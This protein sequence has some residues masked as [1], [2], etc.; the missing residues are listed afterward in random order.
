MEALMNSSKSIALLRAKW[1]KWKDRKYV[2]S[3]YYES[4]SYKDVEYYMCDDWRFDRGAFVDWHLNNGW[5]PYSKPRRK[6]I[7]LPFGP[8][9]TYFVYDKKR[10][11]NK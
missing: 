2:Y 5:R 1:A 4:L 9:N 8:D 7:N 6:Q 3:I 11:E 10:E